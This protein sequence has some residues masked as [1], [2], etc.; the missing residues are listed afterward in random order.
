MARRDQVVRRKIQIEWPSWFWASAALA[1]RVVIRVACLFAGRKWLENATATDK[2]GRQ[3][4]FR[5]QNRVRPFQGDPGVTPDQT[6]PSM[7]P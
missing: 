4:I 6:V 1:E 5:F 3:R 2:T 7:W